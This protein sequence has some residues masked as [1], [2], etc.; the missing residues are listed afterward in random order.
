LQNSLIFPYQE[1]LAFAQRFHGSGGFDE[2][3]RLYVEP[4]LSS[5]QI[6]DPRAYQFDAPV[7]VEVVE[8][9][10]AGYEVV[11]RS[12]WGE[13]G[14]TLMFDQV[15]GG[16]DEASDGWGGDEYIQWFDG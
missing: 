6:I 13:L 3:N 9:A 1:G 11:F 2:V 10:V 14:F 5:E 8:P 7:A 4:P 15:L 16:D 12:T